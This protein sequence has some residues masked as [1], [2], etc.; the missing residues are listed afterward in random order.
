MTYNRNGGQRFAGPHEVSRSSSA[1]GA[2]SFL[3]KQLDIFP[4]C[5]ERDLRVFLNLGTSRL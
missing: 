4:E 5:A 3:L 1:C 2:I